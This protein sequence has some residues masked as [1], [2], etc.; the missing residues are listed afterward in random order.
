MML[1]VAVMSGVRGV[2]AV[3]VGVSGDGVRQL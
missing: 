3:H 1:E 2:R